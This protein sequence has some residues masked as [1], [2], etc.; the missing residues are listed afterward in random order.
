MP[1]ADF[2]LACDCARP[3]LHAVR[4]LV[5]RFGMSFTATAMRFVELCPEPC[6]LVWST[7][8]RIA[9]W[10][11]GE[12][13]GLWIDPGSPLTSGTVAYDAA[14]GERV[15]DDPALVEPDAWGEPW[16]GA[17]DLELW[18]HSVALPEYDAVL[19]LLWQRGA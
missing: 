11:A 3:S 9:W 12:D 19:T 13:F 4:P 15:D 14:R 1:A 2:A 10:D 18:E 8:G 16:R 7:R 17:R 6:A 5:D